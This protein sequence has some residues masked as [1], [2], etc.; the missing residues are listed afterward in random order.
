MMLESKIYMFPHPFKQEEWDIS[1]I[2][3]LKDI[4]VTHYPSHYLH[5]YIDTIIKKTDKNPPIF[6]LIPQRITNKDRTATTRAYT[7][8]CTKSESK[9]MIHLLTHGEFRDKPMFIPFKYKTTQP[10]VFTKCI[11]QQNDVYYKT[12]VIKLEGLTSQAMGYIEEDLTGLNGVLDIIPTKRAEAKGEWKILVEQNRCAFIHSHLKQHW[13]ELMSKIPTDV[14]DM[15]PDTWSIPQ[16]SSQRVRDYQD[17]SSESDSYGSILTAGTNMS[18]IPEEDDKLNDLPPPYGYPTYAAV[19]AASINSETNGTSLSS[20]TESQPSEWQKEKT[21]LEELIK[22]QADQIAKIQAD[23]EVKISRSHDL[24]EQLAQAIELAHTRDARHEE[25]LQKFDQL[26][27]RFKDFPTNNSDAIS[28]P[29]VAGGDSTPRSKNST[30]RP[31]TFE[32]PPSKKSNSN[33]TP[34]KQIYPI[35]QPMTTL[36]MPLPPRVRRATQLMTQPMDTD[37]EMIKPIPGAKPG[38]KIE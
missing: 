27:A 36:G 10:T 35:F 34:E 9:R 3:F 29:I 33:P 17:N 25:M 24:E 38:D 18:G 20:P 32:T 2:G 15:C 19:T 6:Q 4:H 30:P 21:A 5:T 11:R 16:I 1:S 14:M 23:L 26:M 13:N 28:P 31:P 22:T 8:Q 37:D 12:W 7:I